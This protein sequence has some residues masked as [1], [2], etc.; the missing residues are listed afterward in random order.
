MPQEKRESLFFAATTGLMIGV[1]GA[2]VYQRYHCTPKIMTANQTRTDSKPYTLEDLFEKYASPQTDAD[3]K[4]R[5]KWF[6]EVIQWYQTDNGRTWRDNF[7]RANGAREPT[8][9]D[10]YNV[11]AASN[12]M[13]P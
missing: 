9:R 1:V 6:V 10:V 2:S 3:T 11:A 5:I 12:N 7:M 8:I 4:T 13:Q